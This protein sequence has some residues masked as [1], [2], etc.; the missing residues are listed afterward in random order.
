MVH[1][2]PAR[3]ISAHH[4][5]SYPS[6][7]RLQL[8]W[9]PL[10]LSTCPRGSALT[11]SSPGMPFPSSSHG[12]ICIIQASTQRPSQQSSPQAIPSLHP[13]SPSSRLLLVFPLLFLLLSDPSFIF[14]SCL[15]SDSLIRTQQPYSLEPDTQ[16]ELNKYLNKYLLS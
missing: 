4:P 7:S 1:T 9:P 12:L 13:K 10:Y 8:H 3:S 5:P 16:K 14:A 11:N 15:T 6:F 2:V